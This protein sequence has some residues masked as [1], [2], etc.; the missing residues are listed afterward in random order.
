MCIDASR[1]SEYYGSIVFTHRISVLAPDR[2]GTFKCM[3]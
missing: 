1:P 3:K 2:Q